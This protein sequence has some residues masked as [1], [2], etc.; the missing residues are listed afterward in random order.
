MSPGAGG[1]TQRPQSPLQQTDIAS[2][3]AYC[4][5]SC[6]PLPYLGFPGSPPTQPAWS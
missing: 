5:L 4:S 1:V 3:R 6:L 2:I